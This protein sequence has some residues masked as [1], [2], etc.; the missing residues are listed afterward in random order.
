MSTN[1]FTIHNCP[2]CNGIHL[3]H[4]IDCM[5]CYATRENFAIYKCS[6]CGFCFTQDAPVESEIGPYYESPDYISHSDI[7]KGCMNRIYHQVRRYMLKKKADLVCRV[8]GLESGHLLDYGAGTGYF[9]QT[10]RNGGWD[11]K[12]IEKSPMARDF[13]LDHFNLV[14]ESDIALDFLKKQS[15]Q[16]VT[17]WHVMEHVEKLD[18]L[19][20]R[21]FDILVDGGTLIVAVPNCESFDARFYK[22]KWAAYDVPRHLWHFGPNS[23]KKMGERNGFS[24]IEELPMPFDA[25]YVSMLSEK[26][27][28]SSSYFMKGMWNGFRAWLASRNN[29]E[30]SSSLIYVFKKKEEDEKEI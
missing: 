7:H 1:K 12:A 8:S 23:M 22:E 15:F 3:E 21:I 9:A 29:K 24:L 10:M 4:F 19:W 18:Y 2:L 28:G 11:V 30:N 16:V 14:M 25:F 26:Y 27:K 5:D 13:A 17:L 6:D 20:K